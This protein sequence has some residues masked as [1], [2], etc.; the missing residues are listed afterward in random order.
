MRSSGLEGEADSEDDL[1]SSLEMWRCCTVR[2]SLAMCDYELK[3]QKI[4]TEICG[5]GGG[6]EAG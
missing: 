6:E 3:I 5:G 1:S 4:K 2:K